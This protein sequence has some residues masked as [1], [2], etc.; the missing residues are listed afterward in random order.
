MGT[1]QLS[2]FEDELEEAVLGRVE[3]EDEEEQEDEE[4]EEE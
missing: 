1:T 2:M 3:E 4:G